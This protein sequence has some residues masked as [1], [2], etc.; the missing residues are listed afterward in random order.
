MKT[1]SRLTFSGI[2]CLPEHLVLTGLFYS[3]LVLG[4]SF[5][6]LNRTTS[7]EIYLECIKASH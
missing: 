7:G 2:H 3:D 1:G 6:S 4:L 5:S